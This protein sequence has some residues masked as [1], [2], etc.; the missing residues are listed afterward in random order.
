MSGLLT[1]LETQQAGHVPGRAVVD[2]VH[3]LAGLGGL[4][5]LARPLRVCRLL[6]PVKL[7]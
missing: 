1:D 6:P 7:Q 4:D 3:Q 5:G 2:A